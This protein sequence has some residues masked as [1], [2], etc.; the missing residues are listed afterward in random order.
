MTEENVDK[1]KEIKSN[2]KV[3]T[4]Y[5]KQLG[6]NAESSYDVWLSLNKDTADE[7]EITAKKVEMLGKKLLYNQQIIE[8]TK[9]AYLDIK[10]IAGEY[11]KDTIEAET[12]YLNAGKLYNNV[13]AERNNAVSS[14]TEKE[15][16]RVAEINKSIDQENFKAF[17]ISGSKGDLSSF[18]NVKE[19][20]ENYNKFLNDHKE[21][22]LEVGGTYEDLVELAKKK[23][24]DDKI[25][26]AYKKGETGDIALL[27][28]YVEARDMG[29]LMDTQIEQPT[30]DETVVSNAY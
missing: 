17:R 5:L 15:A 16:K 24:G 2:L 20:I 29:T 30:L 10:D 14:A 4:D 12:L 1:I 18:T 8:Y 6:E 26:E 13:L 21:T 9:Q 25:E 3:S 27:K 22:F 28:P 19:I 11:A 23:T 7:I